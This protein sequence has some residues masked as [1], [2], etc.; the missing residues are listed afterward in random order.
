[1]MLKTFAT[2]FAIVMGIAFLGLT[3][4]ATFEERGYYQGLLLALVAG[5]IGAGFTYTFIM[6]VWGAD[7]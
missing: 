2:V 6:L 7:K 4:G 3:F 1:M 5:M